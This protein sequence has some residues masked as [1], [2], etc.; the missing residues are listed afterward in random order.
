M[1]IRSERPLLQSIAPRGA[2]TRAQAHGP[3]ASRVLVRHN[4]SSLSD[5]GRTA[6]L[7]SVL[8]GASCGSPESQVGA[9]PDQRPV[10]REVA[11]ETGLVFEYF[12][13]ASGKF[14]CSGGDLASF[15][16]A[17][18]RMPAAIKEIA[19]HLHTAISRFA[20]MRAP[21]IASQSLSARQRTH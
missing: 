8:L 17:A 7:A 10:F 21:V 3:V 5:L 15:R 14:F 16:G 1:Q 12:I 6:V 2:S 9:G 20:R 18:D 4:R 19:T 13:G 11:T